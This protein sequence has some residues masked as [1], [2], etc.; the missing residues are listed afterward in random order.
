MAD[1]LGASVVLL[2]L[3]LLLLVLLCVSGYQLGP[4]PSGCA[5]AHLS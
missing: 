2:L 1:I 4:G 5:N 3:L